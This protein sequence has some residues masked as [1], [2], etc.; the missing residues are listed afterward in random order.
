MHL[1]PGEDQEQLRSAVRSFL[2][3]RCDEREVRRLMV[4]PEGYDTAVWKQATEQLGLAGLDVPEHLGGSGASFRELAVV[5][6]ELGRTLACLPWL[7]S[8]VLAAGALLHSGDESELLTGVA[9]GTTSAA[10][11]VAE[12]DGSWDHVATSA[13]EVDGRWQLTGSKVFVVDGAAA[14]LL[15]VAAQAPVGLTLF[16]VQGQDQV[17]HSLETL[18]GTR[19]QA[20][21]VLDGAEGRLV[22][23]EGGATDVLARV[24]DR[25]V[26][27]L[28]CENLGVAARTLEMAVAYA[29]ERVQFG[30]SIGSFQAVRHRLADMAGHV[31]AARSA[32]GWAV[33]CAAESSLDLPVAAAMAGVTCT[34]AAVFN[35]AENVQL[36]GGIGFTW[37]HPAHLYFRRARSNAVLLAD[38]AAHRGQLLDRLGV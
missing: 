21:I 7:S 29:K 32:A 18:D 8:A 9:A 34:E 16:A 15:L 35:A 5:A 4:T 33:A 22:G 38:P 31:E 1:T 17:R 6:E 23:V 10:L 26:V 20:R 27:A 30:R 36:H 24:R 28:A 14:D 37:E 2:E 13:T 12:S 19:K 3:R 25:A 11:A